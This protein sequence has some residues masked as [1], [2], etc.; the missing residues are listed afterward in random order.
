[1]HFQG[2]DILINKRKGVILNRKKRDP[3]K[4]IFTG[5]EQNEEIDIQLFQYN[6]DECVE[7]LHVKPSDIGTFTGN[8]YTYWLNIHGLSNPEIIARICKE[9]NI[10]NLT[11]QDILDINQRPKFQ[12]FENFSFL[13][14][15]SI[16]PLKRHLVAEQLSF[17]FNDG[18]LISF[19]ERKADH[20]E[21]L[22]HRLREKKGLLRERGTDFLLYTML[23]AI[24]DNYFKALQQLDDDTGKLDFIDTTTDLPPNIL[25]M[26]ENH[27][28]QVHQIRNAILPIK[29]FALM[30]ERG[31]SQYIE[32][33]HLKYFMEI[34]DLCLTLIDSCDDLQ[35]SLESRTNLFFSIQGHRMNQIMKTLTIVAAI[36]IPLTF[37]AGIYGMNFT[38]MPE[39]YWKYGYATVWFLFISIIAGMMWYFRKKK[40]F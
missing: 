7:Q 40:W 20:F 14:I 31:E 28:K 24:L 11:I 4:F 18:F 33:R 12:E 21:H 5:D 38:N 13:T 19:Q 30:V 17:V 16:H 3:G 29:E 39:L 9:Q 15:K 27:K 1:M 34:K 36:F 25:A 6:N 26:I 22:R 23:E 37:I 8:E 2:M 35:S 32:T 10:H